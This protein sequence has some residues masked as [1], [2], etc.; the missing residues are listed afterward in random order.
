MFILLLTAVIG[1]SSCGNLYDENRT[2]DD[3]LSDDIWNNVGQEGASYD[4]NSSSV[5]TGSTS[6]QTVSTPDETVKAS[7]SSTA[8]T[9]AVTTAVTSGSAASSKAGTTTRRRVKSEQTSQSKGRSDEI[10]IRVSAVT[11]TTARSRTAAAEPDTT[12]AAPISSQGQINWLTA[13]ELLEKLKIAAANFSTEIILDGMVDGNTLSVAFS[14]L[15]TLCPDVFWYENIRCEVAGRQIKLVLTL[16]NGLDTQ[17]VKNMHTQL[18][19]KV[20][21][22]AGKASAAADDYDKILYVHDHIVNNTVYY[23]NDS[24]CSNS[25]Y[26]CL[27][28]GYSAC[29]GYSQAFAL[30]MKKLGFDCGI[31][32]GQADNGHAWNYIKYNGH[33]YWIDCTWDDPVCDD[34]SQVLK[35]DFFMVDDNFLF[36]SRAV[37]QDTNSF[38]PKC[39]S[40]QD[41]YYARKGLYFESFDFDSVNDLLNKAYKNNDREIE[42]IFSGCD[43]ANQF[44][45]EYGNSLNQ[46]DITK[47]RVYYDPRIDQESGKYGFK[48]VFKLTKF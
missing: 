9:T 19:N 24:D 14:K 15:N 35:H 8:G 16:K 40:M 26:G 5:R 18:M 23:I 3:I 29:K 4:Y 1:M 7:E 13:D 12:S 34:G 22:I 27:I 43:E 33:Y 31:C 32:I 36:R 48:T 20:D 28:N 30:I 6:R 37:Y 25:A 38:I 45:K 17:T 10:K 2:A 41:N 47:Q 11:T 42:M 21:E 39:D 46:F 44:I